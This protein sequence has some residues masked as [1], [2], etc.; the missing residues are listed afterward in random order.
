MMRIRLVKKQQMSEHMHGG[1]NVSGGGF[2][3][4]FVPRVVNKT[5]MYHSIDDTMVYHNSGGHCDVVSDNLGI[6][7]VSFYLNLLPIYRNTLY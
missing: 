3:V 5:Y 4:G 2:S 6:D 7:I 1:V